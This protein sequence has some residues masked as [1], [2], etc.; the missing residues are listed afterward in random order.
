MKTL[1]VYA[2]IT[3]NTQKLAE[4][5]HHVLG[6]EKKLCPIDEAPAPNG[7]DLVVIGF[8]LQGG[9][10]DLKSAEYLAELK[11]GTKLFLFATHGAA[12]GSDHVVKAMAHAQSL[13]PTVQLVGTFSCPGQVSAAFLETARKKNPQPPWLQDAPAAQGHP[14]KADVEGLITAIKAAVPEAI[15]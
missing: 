2:S 4:A 7:Y 13:A 6:G 3:G 11:A 1:I 14:D 10:P 12:A 5:I 9:K 15:S 8:W